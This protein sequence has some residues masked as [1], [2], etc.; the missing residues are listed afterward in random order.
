MTLLMLLVQLSLLG[1]WL[2]PSSWKQFLGFHQTQPA[3]AIIISTG[4]YLADRNKKWPKGTYICRRWWRYT[5]SIRVTVV[6]TIPD[7]TPEL[8]DTTSSGC[9]Y[10]CSCYLRRPRIA[11]SGTRMWHTYI[12]TK[13]TTAAGGGGGDGEVAIIESTFFHQFIKI[14][15]NLVMDV[16]T[17]NIIA[18]VGTSV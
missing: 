14:Y 13:A 8:H 10:T 3:S 17:G 6:C 7:K 2:G 9:I 4:T 11:Q 15:N 12:S 18:N 16:T 5:T 1:L